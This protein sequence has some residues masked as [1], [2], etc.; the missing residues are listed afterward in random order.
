[1]IQKLRR[2][3]RFS[4]LQLKKINQFEQLPSLLFLLLH[5]PIFISDYTRRDF[6]GHS[7]RFH[8]ILYVNNTYKIC[9][10]LS[11]LQHLYSI[12]CFFARRTWLEREL[13]DL[14]GIFFFNHPQLQRILTNYG[15]KGHPLR[16]DFP[17]TGFSEIHYFEIRNEFMFAPVILTQNYRNFYFNETW[18]KGR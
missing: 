14:F 6:I 15:F 7:L 2:Y 11:E 13:F 3:S 12:V 5:K 9:F 8:L 17:L 1:M 18:K 16:K 4:T 10:R